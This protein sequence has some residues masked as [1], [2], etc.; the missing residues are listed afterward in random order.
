[1]SSFVVIGPGRAGM[2][3]AL[4]AQRAGH[5]PVGVLGRA[6]GPAAAARLSCPALEWNAALPP[7]DLVIVAVSDDAIAQVVA[8]LVP[9]ESGIVV[10]LSGLA[11]I[12]V[13]A[14]LATAGAGYGALHPL[15][16]L[17]DP[18]RG[19]AALVGAAVAVTAATDEATGILT[20]FSRSLGAEPFRIS[21]DQKPLYHA[22]AAAASNY[23]T[24]VLALAHE[25][26]VEAGV[27]PVVSR[28]LVSAVV[29]N[30][31]EVGP[32]AALTGPIARGDIGTVRALQR[33]AVAAVS[34][35][36]EEAFVVLGRMTAELAGTASVMAGP[37]EGGAFHEDC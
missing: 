31:F 34:P 26:F 9:P 15:Q 30:V 16:T 27:D 28:P 4:A 33:A 21:D 36:L 20:A 10:H 6:G 14:P 12:E 37:L 11:S 32:Q 1:M 35:H 24:T 7:A 17:P 5:T 13:L 29:G 2:S 8:R 19:A 25:L 18:E 23:L 3:M 22:A